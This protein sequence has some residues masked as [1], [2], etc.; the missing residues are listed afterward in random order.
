MKKIRLIQCGVGGFGGGWLKNH[1]SRSVDFELVALVDVSS[2]RLVEAGVI[3][4]IPPA[5]QFSSLE[6]ALEQVE[7]DAVLSVTPPP[8]HVEHAR[9]AF[10]HGLHMITEKPI[11]DTIENACEMVRLAREA[12]REL[13]VSQQYR[14][15]PF[16]QTLRD[17]LQNGEVGGLGHGHLDYY[18]PM[19]FTGTF[20]ETMEFPMLLDMAIHHFDLIRCVT[21]LDVV[22]VNAHSFRPAWSWF[23]HDPGLKMI[24]E[25]EGGVPF[26]YSADWSAL[27]RTTSGHGDW[28][29]QCSAGSL[30]LDNNRVLVERCERWGKNRSTEEPALPA[31]P[32]TNQDATLH[33][34][35]EA[36]RSGV[37]AEISGADNLGS[38]SVIAAAMKS[39]REKREILLEECMPQA[40]ALCSP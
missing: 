2:E 5:R 1:T 9:L 28:R 20:R 17:L 34:F 23:Q 40:P 29:L 38:F 7:A 36:I 25:L 19:D 18:I 37:P 39:I 10:A 16:I 33:A 21:G 26:S 4:G 13:V 3:A 32:Y 15:T 35:A 14:F 11:A 6:A 31:I 12:G 22:K 27:G 8:V 24:M 30:H